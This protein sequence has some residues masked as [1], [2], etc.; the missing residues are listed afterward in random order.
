M[1]EET[2]LV[3]FLTGLFRAP[4][5]FS[6]G[7]TA[8][9]V[10]N[11]ILDSSN[12]GVDANLAILL[13]R[14]ADGLLNQLSPKASFAELVHAAILTVK[15]YTCVLDEHKAL[16]CIEGSKLWTEKFV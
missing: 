1:R 8:V 2:V 10:P 9:H 12:P 7:F 13:D 16:C 6:I 4:F 11:H 15:S 5:W 14:Y 3:H